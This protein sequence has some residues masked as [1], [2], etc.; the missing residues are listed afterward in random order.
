MYNNLKCRIAK[1][2]TK[3]FAIGGLAAVIAGSVLLEYDYFGRG[4]RLAGAPAP[5]SRTENAGI[6]AGA[7]ADGRILF[8][9]AGARWLRFWLGQER[10][11]HLSSGEK[12]LLLYYG[13]GTFD[14]SKYCSGINGASVLEMAIVCDNHDMESHISK[15]RSTFT[16][17]GL[18]EKAQPNS[19]GRLYVYESEYFNIRVFAGKSAKENR[20]FAQKALAT[21]ENLIIAYRGDM[22]YMLKNFPHNT[23][24]GH[25]GHVLFVNGACFGANHSDKYL[26]ASQVDLSII[27]YKDV[28]KGDATTQILK[29]ILE[30]HKN[31]KGACTYRELA[32]SLHARI[33]NAGVKVEILDFPKPQDAM[34]KYVDACIGKRQR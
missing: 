22:Q 27:A 9:R 23:F 29:G 7:P 32:E 26:D 4:N 33:E 13:D 8:G 34:K 31:R 5:A 17:M 6:N 20:E 24:A 3:I 21:T 28:A 18:L 19:D 12:E 30:R 11:M 16:A 25:A 1:Q 14:P 2:A 10:E 15:T